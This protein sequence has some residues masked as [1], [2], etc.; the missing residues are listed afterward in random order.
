[1]FKNYQISQSKNEIKGGQN[2]ILKVDNFFE[3]YTKEEIFYLEK[4]LLVSLRE[5]I[6]MVY[7]FLYFYN[8]L[9]HF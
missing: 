2:P 1:M 4:N 8:Y 5:A 3:D 7:N 9:I 6:K